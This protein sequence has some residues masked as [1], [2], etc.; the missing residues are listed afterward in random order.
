M[1]ISTNDKEVLRALAA[2][3]MKYAHS[4]ANDEKRELWRA[5]NSLNMQKPMIT[6]DQMPWHEL[7][8]D[9]ALSCVVEN[10]Y[11]R[12]VEWRLRTEIYKWEHLR[13]DMV[14]NPYVILPR[15]I[16][17][18]GFGMTTVKSDNDKSARSHL[19]EDQL[20]EM[21]DIEKIK[22]PK[23]SLD[24]EKEDEILSAAQE[25]FDG[26]AP[27]KWSGIMVHSGLWDQI[28]FWKGVENCYIDLIDRPEL[29]HA[30][31]DRYTNAHLSYIKEINSL[32]V[33][34]TV[35]N[36]CHCSY[37]FDNE[38]TVND[39]IATHATTHDGWT[40]SMAQLFTSVSPATNE[41]FELPYM[42]KIFSQYG[43][44]YYGC[45]ERLD[46]R[47]HIIDR[48]PNIRKISCSP[49]SDRESFA[50][51]LPQKY[52]MSNKPS[53]SF[54]ATSTFDEDAV[55]QDLRRTIKAAKDH[56]LALE[57]LLKDLSTVNNDPSRLWRWSEIALEETINSV[58]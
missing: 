7:K 10:D 54:L 23:L 34:D 36:N 22:L 37:T 2:K 46:D 4:E 19:F 29:I 47:L 6:I 40:F 42:S 55:R 38:T 51:N 30:I 43:S 15:P 12:K 28:S 33:Y 18:T 13:A 45:C 14:L 11:F 27:I 48:L 49:W 31:L 53:P 20:E 8:V 58:L 24:T 35:S 9:E 17:N 44:V 39:E 1:K 26:I 57:L 25:I 21:E 5:L 16:I 32:G 41:E 52:I 56:N 50:A 3:Y